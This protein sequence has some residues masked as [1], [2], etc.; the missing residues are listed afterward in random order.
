MKKKLLYLVTVFC[1]LV[2][3]SLNPLPLKAAESTASANTQVCV[4]NEIVTP[5]PTAEIID[6]RYK[7]EDGKMYKRL[8]NYSRNQWVGDWILCP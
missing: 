3:L 6:W 1:A 5:V 4:Q 2:I 7:I 8:F